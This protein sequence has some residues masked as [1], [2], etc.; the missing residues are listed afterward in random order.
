MTV[1]DCKSSERDRRDVP[2]A[3]F[4]TLLRSRAGAATDAL[5]ET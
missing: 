3:T 1:I 2:A 4:S 5:A